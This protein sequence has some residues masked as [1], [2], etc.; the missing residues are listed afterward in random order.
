MTENFQ[1]DE[2]TKSDTQFTVDDLKYGNSQAGDGSRFRRR[3]FFGL[4]GRVMYQRLQETMPQYSSLTNPELV[5]LTQNAI[6][7]AS[8]RW[9][10][11][12]LMNEPPLTRY[13]DGSFYGFSMLWYKLNGDIEQ[14]S[15]GTKYYSIFLRQLQCGGDLYSGEGPKCQYNAT[16]Q[17]TCSVGCIKG[18]EDSSTYC[19]CTGSESKQCPSSPKHILCC[20]DTCSQ[21]LKMDLGIVLDASGSVGESNYQLQLNFTKDLIQR[22]NVGSNKT[23]VGIINYS[24]DIQTLTWL[25]KDYSLVD[26]L[27]LVNQAVY[28]GQ[29]TRTSIAL[30]QADEVFSY[31]S[32][33]RK[34]E[35]GVTPVIFVITDG[36]SDNE[37]LTI[38]AANVLKQKGIILVSVG[39]GNGPKLSELHAICSLPI[40]ENYF[41]ISNYT[42][43]E[44]K[45]NQ[46]TSKSCSEP[47]F[48]S[49]NATV[50][51]GV[52]KDKYKFLKIEIIAIGNKILITAILAKGDVKLFH[53]FTNRNPKDP[54]DFIDYETT[55]DLP[56]SRWM[57]FKSYFHRSSTTPLTTKKE[58]RRID[59]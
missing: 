9:I 13:A 12:D 57:Q 2:I 5:A 58:L 53:S 21:D 11:P 55:R 28:Y 34:S 45:L 16:H 7:I 33:R 59:C 4:R 44:Q 54:A 56:L 6:A 8:K 1:T 15:I 42:A 25:N 47:T 31:K 27:R 18:L 30:Q 41:V 29:G 20:L 49:S 19:G 48:L 32:G 10:N 24:T 17:G 52:N 39:V 23:R 36:A 40:H 38:Q 37:T 50:T 3:G 22:V 14:L 46:F 51:A 26:K 43:L 35:E